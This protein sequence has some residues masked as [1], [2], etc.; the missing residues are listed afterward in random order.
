MDQSNKQQK[1]SNKQAQQ[2]KAKKILTK[3]DVFVKPIEEVTSEI[4]I[5]KLEKSLPKVSLVD[6]IEEENDGNDE[7]AEQQLEVF[8][9]SN[10]NIKIIKLQT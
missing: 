3:A 1:T 8:T 4:D 2:Q 5:V 10:V 7:F 6:K 9:N